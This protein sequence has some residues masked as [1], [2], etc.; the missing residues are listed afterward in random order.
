M[1]LLLLQSSCRHA[2]SPLLRRKRRSLSRRIEE[3]PTNP[4]VRNGLPKGTTDLH[5][6][7]V[8]SSADTTMAELSEFYDM[9]NRDTLENEDVGSL[10]LVFEKLWINNGLDDINGIIS[11]IRAKRAV[12]NT[13][14]ERNV[15]VMSASQVDNLV[16]N[17]KG[18]FEEH[19]IFSD[20]KNRGEVM[21][22]PL[23]THQVL[24]S[25]TLTSVTQDMQLGETRTSSEGAMQTNSEHV[26]RTN[27]EG[28]MQTNSEHVTQTSSE[29]AMQTNNE[30]VT[31]TSGEG[32]MQTNS[33]HVTRT[34]SED[35]MQTNSEHVTRTSSE[36]AM[37]TNNEGVTRT[38]G[39]G[40]MQTNNEGMTRTSSKGAIQTNSYSVTRTSSEGATQTN[41][42]SVT[43]T[44]SESVMQTSIGGVTRTSSEGAMQTNSE[45][46]TRTSNEGMMQTSSEDVTRTSSKGVTSNED[47][48]GTSSEGMTETSSEEMT[49]TSGE[50]RTRTSS[51]GMA[52]TSREHITAMSSEGMPETS[53]DSVIGI[54]SESV[55]G[56]RIEGLKE[57]NEV[58]ETSSES[59]PETNSEGVIETS[60]EGVT[61]SSN[62]GL[63]ETIS[64]VGT[65]TSIGGMAGT[66]SEGLTEIS[67]RGVTETSTGGMTGMSSEGLTETSGRGVT[68]TSTG[69]MTGTS[70][71]GLTET[72]GRGVTET[73]TGG[74][75][76]TSSEGLTET[77]GRGV[78]ET[79]TGGMTGT[80]SEGLTEISGRGVT[81]TSSDGMTETNSEG[82]TETSNKSMPETSNAGFASS[83]SVTEVGNRGMAGTS[84]EGLIETSSRDVTETSSNGVTATGKESLTEASSRG[85]TGT[86][87]GGVIGTSSKSLTET[88]SEGVTE[89]SSEGVTRTSSEWLAETSGNVVTE[90][91]GQN[92]TE[93]DSEG[94]METSGE[95]MSETSSEYVTETSNEAM[96]ETSNR[97]I[98]RTSDEGGTRTS[99]DGW[100]D[101]SS[102]AVTETSRGSRTETGSEGLSE[103]SSKYMTKT[104]SKDVTET[105][106]RG[107]NETS[108]E[109]VTKTSS[110]GRT[111]TNIKSITEKSSESMTETSIEDVAEMSSE[112]MKET[113]S[114]GITETSI[115]F[116]NKNSRDHVTDTSKDGV[117]IIGSKGVR[118]TSSEGVT[119]TS[120]E[121]GRMETNS[122]QNHT[123][124]A[125]FILDDDSTTQH[126]IVSDILDDVIAQTITSS[127]AATAQEARRDGEMYKK[128]VLD[129]HSYS[130]LIYTSTTGTIRGSFY[131]NT[132][133]NI[134]KNTEYIIDRDTV[135]SL[136]PM[137]QMA[138]HG[139]K[140]ATK[141]SISEKDDVTGPVNKIVTE[142]VLGKDSTFIDD[143]N[144]HTD[145][146]LIVVTGG[147]TSYQD[148]LDLLE[149]QSTIIR[150]KQIEPVTITTSD[151]EGYINHLTDEFS[152][153]QARGVTTDEI[154]Q[155]SLGDLHLKQTSTYTD[156][157]TNIITDQTHQTA[158][159]HT[160]IMGSHTG[161]TEMIPSVI[162]QG[163]APIS[164]SSSADSDTLGD[165]ME[166]MVG[167]SSAAT[168]SAGMHEDMISTVT[169]ADPAAT[170]VS[171]TNTTQTK[172][173]ENS[174]V[175]ELVNK[176]PVM[177]DLD[178]T[179]T[180]IGENTHTDSP[181][182]DLSG[183]ED[184]TS[185][186]E[187]P[188][189]PENQPTTSFFGEKQ[190]EATIITTGD[191]KDFVTHSPGS[192]SDEMSHITITDDFHGDK[193]NKFNQD[194]HFES[195]HIVANI[196]DHQQPR[197]V[198]ADGISQTPLGDFDPEQTSTLS[199]E[200]PIM[201]TDQ[202]QPTDSTSSHARGSHTKDI[203]TISSVTSQR[204]SIMVDPD[205]LLS[206]NSQDVTNEILP[207]TS[208]ETTD[209][210]TQSYM[211]KNT[212]INI[213][214]DI[215]S[216]FLSADQMVFL[217]SKTT[218][219][220]FSAK[221][222]VTGS[223]SK[224]PMVTAHDKTTM[225]IGENIQT[226]SPSVDSSAMTESAT[227]H[228][229]YSRLGE[230]QET[231][232]IAKITT[233][234]ITKLHN[235]DVGSLEGFT[236]ETLGE[237]DI[238]SKDYM[239]I[240]DRGSQDVTLDMISEIHTMADDTHDTIKQTVS[241][242]N[243]KSTGIA[244]SGETTGLG[245]NLLQE[246]SDVQTQ[247]Y[248]SSGIGSRDFGARI[249]IKP[250][251]PDSILTTE[252]NEILNSGPTHTVT[253]LQP[254][255]RE[256]D[257]TVHENYMDEH[258][259]SNM[260]KSALSTFIPSNKM[261]P[262][263]SRTIQAD[264]SEK[265]KISEP[266]NET[267]MMTTLDKLIT[268]ISETIQADFPSSDFSE[269]TESTHDYQTDPNPF[270]TEETSSIAKITPVSVTKRHVRDS[271]NY[272][273]FAVMPADDDIDSK[274]ITV[275]AISEDHTVTDHVD[276]TVKRTVSSGNDKSTGIRHSKETTGLSDSLL[277]GNVDAL[278]Q[279]A[280]VSG[281]ESSDFGGSITLETVSSD[282]LKTTEINDTA[283]VTLNLYPTETVTSQQSQSHLVGTTLPGDEQTGTYHSISATGTQRFDSDGV[284]GASRDSIKGEKESSTISITRS[285]AEDFTTHLTDDFSDKLSTTT[286]V[287]NEEDASKS[288]R[289][290][291]DDSVSMVA[292]TIQQQ[293]ASDVNAD[294]IGQVSQANP[295][296]EQTSAYTHEIPN[297]MPDQ[298]EPAGS[299]S[300][301]IMS[302][303]MREMEMISFA[304]A[305]S[306]AA[307]I[308]PNMPNSRN[309]QPVTNEYVLVTD[310]TSNS[311][312]PTSAQG[313][314]LVH[315]GRNPHLR[316]IRGELTT[317]GGQE[318]ESEST[319]KDALTVTVGS[320]Q[321]HIR[322]NGKEDLTTV[323][324]IEDSAIVEDHQKNNGNKGKEV[325]TTAGSQEGETS[326][327]YTMLP[328]GP[329]HKHKESGKRKSKPH[330]VN[331]TDTLPEIGPSPDLKT[332]SSTELPNPELV[333]RVNKNGTTSYHK[334]IPQL[335]SS[336]HR[337][338][339]H[340]SPYNIQIFSESPVTAGSVPR[341][342]FGNVSHATADGNG[343]T[344][345]HPHQQT[346]M[347]E[348]QTHNVSTSDFHDPLIS[349]VFD[350]KHTVAGVLQES[351]ISTE[352]H[353][354]DT[355]ESGTFVGSPT[356]SH[357]H[358]SREHLPDNTD[359]ASPNAAAAKDEGN[360]SP[361]DTN[362][363]ENEATTISAKDDD[364]QVSLAKGE[365][366]VVRIIHDKEKALDY[367]LEDQ[368]ADGD[369]GK[370]KGKDNVWEIGKQ[371]YT[372]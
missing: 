253:T 222:E 261:I 287:S 221:I 288:N 68:E 41:I 319:E 163:Y 298:T 308:N 282:S 96:T 170:F 38:S 77:S 194:S 334:P 17:Y 12:L 248:V 107:M 2:P 145:P 269:M 323:G 86:S 360:E 227:G 147:T 118:E 53:G 164:L 19:E 262:R 218:P 272:D 119:E 174:Y 67:G 330:A 225:N 295:Q 36:G 23:N 155:T 349:D 254:Q 259:E 320:H 130:P 214:E 91:S 47:A 183:T 3:N 177:A 136:I 106:N 339:P 179:I 168:E 235:P 291:S 267:P 28:T 31:R 51:E 143:E 371:W 10:N 117:T 73:S 26:T 115:K 343:A 182:T 160:P 229:D 337:H 175:T 75:T 317:D 348:P 313:D 303:R 48:I 255:S 34:N 211:D 332:S 76:G 209:R 66:S 127:F 328:S 84:S 190:N 344:G 146:A 18:R 246:K 220:D 274:D 98:T 242:D 120:I 105:S 11:K 263:G 284:T 101:A 210:G 230:I 208:I 275:G 249:T 176:T 197:D 70:S 270:E 14:E 252:A 257:I 99:S 157:T 228:E 241:S 239:D 336:N 13:G 258:T 24:S 110:E 294:E 333:P 216:V 114:K 316:R 226:D 285:A 187:D 71:E 364:E 69:G 300:S 240:N 234:S 362:G 273:E 140:T 33:E 135:S 93:T 81:E 315:T 326:D 265:D 152:D 46:V 111:E 251:S 165:I 109:G 369:G 92:M 356:S 74:M 178:R 7:P 307:I 125:H 199:G 82:V 233:V 195:L 304:T 42:E 342:S 20:G 335:P 198:T 324:A 268:F 296:L 128:I 29:G 16:V 142:T 87:K 131:G 201:I 104:S 329:G 153:Q 338:T 62:G 292:S 206:T 305:Q 63:T 243:G 133:S 279:T 90:T 52:E 162:A 372:V 58:T 57:T 318:T 108:N 250:I 27:S 196:N 352:T 306:N 30:G 54:S 366:Q 39:E 159:A 80:S 116:V 264:L 202:T 331:D 236:T 180:H 9:I 138:S 205:I 126:F 345:I 113:S 309:S 4:E 293:Q 325:L 231:S 299:L 55:T 158:S 321:K 171:K 103:T 359:R 247:I 219:T 72:S 94:V 1:S 310:E 129:S 161:Q 88:N 189:P 156:E 141:A 351:G 167:S 314:G 347:D 15:H 166:Q 61:R 322:D 139:S 280:V 223:M 112:G 35:T 5:L 297:L 203:K 283:F 100:V 357:D 289:S 363:R 137:D 123:S 290:F 25:S 89:T 50:S 184:I 186:Q 302:S 260:G 200:I 95:G 191:T 237:D 213:E 354:L 340:T 43:R 355:S 97:G 6:A 277:Q 132:Q 65:E 49:E 124:I 286:L 134:D 311:E 151:T 8:D 365:T 207:V 78:T 244:R 185:Y 327:T 353:P 22:G 40:T 172:L 193:A 44:I 245:E 21:D 37:Q 358:R 181:F 370:G 149:T 341:S 224:L 204:Y 350:E 59:I 301:R 238:T 217:N 148:H 154:D 276:E 361:D 56:T 45:S 150:G 60:S 122:S 346:A 312:G 32:T 271:E 121:D 83:I 102:E 144:I 215:S 232:L 173:S 281:I 212:E 266:M 85:V 192:V 367:K 188:D 64:R 278:T 169:S 79:S 256:G 368:E